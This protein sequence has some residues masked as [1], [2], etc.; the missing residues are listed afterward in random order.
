M[1]LVSADDKPQFP[2]GK[3]TVRI[4]ALSDPGYV[5]LRAF[6]TP[7]IPSFIVS[8]RSVQEH[9]G[10]DNCSGYSLMTNFVDNTFVFTA[11]DRTAAPVVIPGD[12]VSSLNYTRAI[13][14]PLFI[15]STPPPSELDA[16]IHAITTGTERMLWHQRLAHCS[17][18]KL[19]HAHKYGLGVP[20]F[21]GYTA[22]VENCPICIAAKMKN[23]A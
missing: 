14:P 1:C 5:D 21:S 16:T 2:L 22:L 12:V 18:E 4:P 23:C 3:G 10:F 9:I 7:G 11:K 17:D 15:D 6:H 13:I 20:K 8:P 19:A